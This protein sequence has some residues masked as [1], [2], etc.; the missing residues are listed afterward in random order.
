M[1]ADTVVC[2]WI[3]LVV[4]WFFAPY[5]GVVAP[6]PVGRMGYV[7]VLL[8]SIAFAVVARWIRKRSDSVGVDSDG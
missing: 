3:V 8:S 4:V 7:L 1:I 5:L 2:G 6:E